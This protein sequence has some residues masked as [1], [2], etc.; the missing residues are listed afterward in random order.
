MGALR[1]TLV[2]RSDS[3]ALGSIPALFPRRY[4]F[5]PISIGSM[6]MAAPASFRMERVASMISGPMPSPWATVMGTFV[7]IGEFFS[8]GHSPPA[9]GV[10]DCGVAEPEAR[11]DKHN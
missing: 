8:I 9:Q 1:K 10:L 11:A 7:V 5:S 6:S 2:R 3:Q 4:T